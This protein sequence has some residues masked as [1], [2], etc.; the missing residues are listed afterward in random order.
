MPTGWPPWVRRRGRSAIPMP[1]PRLPH[2]WTPMPAETVPDGSPTLDL[3]ASPRIHVVGIGG[4]GMSA[5]AL[6][7]AAMGHTVSGSDLKDSPVATRLRSHGIPVSV[8]HRAEHV[9]HVDAVTYSPAVG[10]DN[11]E[12]VAARERGV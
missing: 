4:A 7:L 11:P 3:A 6:V 10:L 2:W 9:E 8:G 1:R 5:I 12:L